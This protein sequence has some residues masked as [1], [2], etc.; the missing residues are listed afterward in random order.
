MFD[1]PRRG[2]WAKY[3][4][5]RIRGT[6]GRRILVTDETRPS[7]QILLDSTA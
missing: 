5:Y 3:A 4:K 7:E 2:A 6:A 1:I